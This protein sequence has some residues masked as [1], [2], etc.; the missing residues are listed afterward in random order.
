M[1]TRYTLNVAHVLSER[2]R[3]NLY[4]GLGCPRA[5]YQERDIHLSGLMPRIE[6]KKELP[7]KNRRIMDE[8]YV[9]DSK[10]KNKTDVEYISDGLPPQF[11]VGSPQDTFLDHLEIR[12]KYF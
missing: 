10:I 3:I 7:R 12:M 4:S 11:F 9:V 2:R 5:S 6:V 8:Y 1:E